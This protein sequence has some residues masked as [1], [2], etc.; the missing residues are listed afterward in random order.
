[1]KEQIQESEVQS[2]RFENETD[3]LLISAEHRAKGLSIR[4]VE[5]KDFGNIDTLKEARLRSEQIISVHEDTEIENLPSLVLYGIGNQAESAFQLL[6]TAVDERFFRFML[7]KKSITTR[8]L[9]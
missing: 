2:F 3:I 1:M 4:A 5:K 7:F 6:R 9:H 8:I